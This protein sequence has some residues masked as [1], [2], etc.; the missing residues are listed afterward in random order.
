M[1]TQLVRATLM[2]KTRAIHF[3]LTATDDQWNDLVDNVNS[4][5]LHEVMEGEVIDRVMGS[6]ASG[7]CLCRI[8]NSQTQQVKTLFCLPM[9]KGEHV[10][11]LEQPV[12]IEKDD[13]LQCLPHVEE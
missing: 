8:W 3:T 7:S 12:K 6:Y 11:M 1:T 9:V 10:Q 5:D 13:I 2:S 4:L